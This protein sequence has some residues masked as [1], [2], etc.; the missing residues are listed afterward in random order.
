[1]GRQRGYTLIEVLTAVAVLVILATIALPAYANYMRKAKIHDAFTFLLALHTK[2]QL[3]WTDAHDYG[4]SACAIGALAG[5]SKYFSYTCDINNSQQ[6]YLITAK[7]QGDLLNYNFTIDMNGKRQ[8]ID[9]PGVSGLPAQCWLD[10]P[11][12][13][14]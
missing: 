13:C 9:F 14:P 5:T 11:G 6:G 3:Y 12:S 2:E 4:P 1:M 7:G 8:T 10:A